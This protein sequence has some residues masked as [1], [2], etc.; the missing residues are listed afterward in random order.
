MRDEL[1]EQMRLRVNRRWDIFLFRLLLNVGTQLFGCVATWAP[2]GNI[3]AIHFAKSRRDL[4]LSAHA[5]SVCSDRAYDVSQP[6]N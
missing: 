3:R 5:L 6:P 4:H 1:I 2:D